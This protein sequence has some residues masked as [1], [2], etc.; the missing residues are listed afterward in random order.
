MRN[1][2]V[3]FSGLCFAAVH[4]REAG[5]DM[6]GSL[7]IF[8]NFPALIGG[9]HGIYMNLMHSIDDGGSLR[10]I[11]FLYLRTLISLTQKH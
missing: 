1:T 9:R 5:K 8:I 11:V 10:G 7:C 2:R 6:L 4:G 3:G